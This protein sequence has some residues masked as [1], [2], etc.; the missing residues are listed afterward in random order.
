MISTGT[1][2]PDAACSGGAGVGDSTAFSWG[3]SSLWFWTG[4]EE[5]ERNGHCFE[6]KGARCFLLHT[7]KPWGKL[8]V[9]L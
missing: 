5:K 2:F 3:Y 4:S 7:E 1:M 9:D 8:I 6:W